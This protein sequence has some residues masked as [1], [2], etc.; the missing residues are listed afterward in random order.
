MKNIISHIS[1]VVA[2]LLLIGCSQTEY[3][4][5]IKTSIYEP[6]ENEVTITINSKDDG[7]TTVKQETTTVINSTNKK[8]NTSEYE[9]STVSTATSS[10]ASSSTNVVKAPKYPTDKKLTVTSTGK[11]A[12]HK[13][14]SDTISIEL[15]Q[16]ETDTKQSYWLAHIVI[17]SPNQIRGGLSFDDYGGTRETPTSASKRLGWTLGINGSYFSYDTGKPLDDVIIKDGKKADN[18]TDISAGREICLKKDG[19]I[20][21]PQNGTTADQLLQ[22][23]VVESWVTRD[24]LMLSDG[25]RQRT[26]VINE[27]NPVGSKAYPRTAIGMVEPCN[28][29]IIVAGEKTEESGLSFYQMQNI[30]YDLNCEYARSFDGGGSSALVYKNELLNIPK[31]GS[32][33]AVVDFLYFKE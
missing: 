2:F 22:M 18:I 32:E 6:S 1:L 25:K 17:K 33:R 30:F 8:S 7:K 26:N 19:T 24:P 4:A 21:T 16:Y 14:K 13:Y 23:G 15:Q 12:Y 10:V 28:Y 9:T 11:P 3:I 5:D 31:G 27:S 29:Y 20:F